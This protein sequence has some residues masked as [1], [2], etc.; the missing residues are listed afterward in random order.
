MVSVKAQC[1]WYKSVV[2]DGLVEGPIRGDDVVLKSQAHVTGDI[3]H[4]SLTIEKGA[5]F[6]GRSKQAMPKEKEEAPKRGRTKKEAFAA[7]DDT[8]S[9]NSS[10]VA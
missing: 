9:G 8:A 1:H 3:H 4:T 10:A 2:V 5:I 7:N 6:D